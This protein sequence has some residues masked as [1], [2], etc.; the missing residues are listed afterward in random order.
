MSFRKSWIGVY[1]R[2]TLFLSRFWYIGEWLPIYN[3]VNSSLFYTMPFFIEG[4]VPFRLFLE[5][6]RLCMNLCSD[7]VIGD[8]LEG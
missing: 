2:V 8:R 4:G 6:S 1:V 3:R 5:I 7:E